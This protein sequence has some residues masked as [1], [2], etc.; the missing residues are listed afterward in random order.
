MQISASRSYTKFIV[1][2]PDGMR[3]R[4]K[5][6]ARANGR[7]MNAEIVFLLERSFQE[8]GPAEAATSP[9]H[10]T[11]TPAKG[12]R[13]MAEHSTSDAYDARLDDLVGAAY[14][15]GDLLDVM[16]DILDVSGGR[17]LEKRKADRLHSLAT[18][19]LDTLQAAMAQAQATDGAAA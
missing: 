12:N 3:D 7:S 16:R 14:R 8:N 17:D 5:A 13:M 10:V 6:A 2:L 15:V 11:K 19:A 18:V 1:R 9:S 4:I